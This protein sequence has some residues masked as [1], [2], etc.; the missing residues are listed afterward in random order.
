M[1]VSIILVNYNTCSMTLECVESIYRWTSGLTFE[2]IVVDNASSDNSAA[3]LGSDGRVRFIGAGSNIGFGRAN[4]I[5]LKYASGEYVLLLN[6]DTYLTGNAIYE[7]WK[8]LSTTDLNVG[9]LGTIL[10]DKNG[11]D[12]HS[13][14]FFP[15]PWSSLG[16]IFKQ[17]IAH[18]AGKKRQYGM[19]EISYSPAPDGSCYEVDYV[20]GADLMARRVTFEKYGAFDPDFFLYYEETEMQYRWKKAGLKNVII[21]VRGICHLEGATTGPS[22]SDGRKILQ[23]RSERLYFKKIMS[24]LLYPVF[25]L[26][27]HIAYLPLLM[28]RNNVPAE[29]VLAFDGRPL[30]AKMT[31]IANVLRSVLDSLVKHHPE[32]RI[33]IFAP[34][35]FDDSLDRD[36]CKFPNVTV[37]RRKFISEKLPKLIW[38]N[39]HMPFIMRGYGVTD[40]VSVRTELPLWLPRKIR[41]I[42]F[43]HDV[44][45]IEYP[46]TMELKNR[47][48]NR[49][50][51]SRTIRKADL[52]WCVSNYTKSRVVNYFPESEPRIRMVGIGAGTDIFRDLSLSDQEKK[53]YLDELGV[54]GRPLLFVGSLE[55]RKNL[56]FLLDLMPELYRRG[57]QLIVVGAKGWKNSDIAITVNAPGFPKESVI[58]TGYVSDEELVMLYNCAECYVSTSLNEGFGLPQLEAMLC[59]CR[60]VSPDN[61]AMSEVVGGRGVLVSSWNKNEWIDTIESYCNTPVGAVD[62]SPF[63]WHN[64][65]DSFVKVL[66]R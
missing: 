5:G 19:P 6:S 11:A 17:H 13:S 59:G 39:L 23:C 14:A 43:V 49:I 28:R 63:L 29:S 8:F 34:S 51:F 16:I 35:A 38:Y 10:Q 21:P 41:R 36:Y 62:L 26:C 55:P 66:R 46:E 9:A 64:L 32:I 31:G 1:D 57:F 50:F 20:T 25:S 54:T 47:L 18:L 52:L 56:S 7:M 65:I 27:H 4:N 45:A 53:E 2:V 37:V 3:V 24:R 40:F 33:I 44:V 60:V 22:Q 12:T 61:S 30:T 58:F 48:V 15:K 42:A